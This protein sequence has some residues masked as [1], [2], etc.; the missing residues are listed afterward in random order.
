MSSEQ[1]NK[2]YNRVKIKRG[3]GHEWEVEITSKSNPLVLTLWLSTL[4]AG[5]IV[6]YIFS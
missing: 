1:D 6:L 4:I 3:R 2:D 5:F